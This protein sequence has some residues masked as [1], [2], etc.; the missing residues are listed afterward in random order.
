MVRIQGR[1]AITFRVVFLEGSGREDVVL[2]S[3]SRHGIV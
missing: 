2:V 1:V 3:L